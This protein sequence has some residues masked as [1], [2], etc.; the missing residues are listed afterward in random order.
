MFA[1]TV[2]DAARKEIERINA[3]IEV[4]NKQR[5][6]P[7]SENTAWQLRNEIETLDERKGDVEH[8]QRIALNLT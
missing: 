1:E 6:E 3:R 4:L 8:I 2:L 7:H 5:D